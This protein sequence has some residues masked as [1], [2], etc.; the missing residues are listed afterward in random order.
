MDIV[1]NFSGDINTNALHSCSMIS[2]A[3]V[4][5]A[6]IPNVF[7]AGDVVEADCN[8][9]DVVL[10]RAG[11]LEGHLEPRYGALGN[12][13]EDFE[14]RPGQNIIRAVWSDW[15]NTSYKPTIQIIFNEVYL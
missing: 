5:F 4:P 9:A 3:G 13:W 2:K 6:E 14:I 11:S 10:Y 1:F 7:T 12:D 15:V 8:S